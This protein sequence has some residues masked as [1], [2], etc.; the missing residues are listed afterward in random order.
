MSQSNQ[1]LVVLKHVGKIG[2]KT[3]NHVIISNVFYYDESLEN[4]PY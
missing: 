2:N 1:N 4:T 3:D